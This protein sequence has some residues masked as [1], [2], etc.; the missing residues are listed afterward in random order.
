MLGDAQ[1]MSS[2]NLRKKKLARYASIYK[3][4]DCPDNRCIYC[5][6]VSDTVDHVPCL[7][8]LY[9]LGSGFFE[10]VGIVP[11]KFPACRECNS[12]LGNI[13]LHK[14]HQRGHYIHD[15]F[16]KKYAK[17]LGTPAFS[18][19]EIEEFDRGLRHTIENRETVKKWARRRAFEIRL[20]FNIQ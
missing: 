13:F 3:K 8:A 1:K 11:Q 14:L 19:E 18:Q 7:D 12:F 16:M 15:K 17:I 5:G 6:D 10:D 20:R 9:C 2:K 4:A